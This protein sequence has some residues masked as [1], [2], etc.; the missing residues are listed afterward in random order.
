MTS[1]SGCK[2]MI[3]AINDVYI[4]DNIPKFRTLV[5]LTVAK[6]KP[7]HVFI[8]H[9]GDFLSPS[10]LSNFDKGLNMVQVLNEGGFSHIVLGNHEFDIT[11]IELKSRLNLLKGSILGTNVTFPKNEN[12]EYNVSKYDIT[13]LKP[14]GIKIGW[15]GFL[16][17]ETVT[18][19]KTGGLYPKYEG[20]QVHDPIE[21]A[22]EAILELKTKGVNVIILLTHLD[23]ARDRALAEEAAK[24][25]IKLILGGH[26]HSK[27]VEKKHGVHVV[28][29]G[30]D[31]IE[32]TVA[33]L[34]FRGDGEANE[35][36]S[37]EGLLNIPY[38]VSVDVV[39]VSNVKTDEI[40]Y[41][42]MLE[43]CKEGY[44]KLKSLGS[45]LLIPP[46]PIGIDILSSKNPRNGQCTV[47]R[48]FGDVMKKFFR[49][50]A[51]IINSGKI[52]NKSEYPDGLTLTNIGSE[53]P[54]QDNFTYSV[55]MTPAELEEVLQ[56]SYKNKL[57]A[58]GFLQFDNKTNFDVKTLTLQS[59]NGK[60]VTEKSKSQSIMVAMPI[61]I[62]NGMD[63]II[64]LAKIG[65]RNKTKRVPLDHLM[66]MQDIIIKQCVLDQWDEL[67]LTSLDFKKADRDQDS[68]VE[69]KEFVEYL[70]KSHPEFGKG[71]VDLFWENLDT[72]GNG[73]LTRKEFLRRT[74]LSLDEESMKELVKFR[75]AL[76]EGRLS[77]TSKRSSFLSSATSRQGSSADGGQDTPIKFNVFT[78]R[79]HQSV[80][81][82]EIDE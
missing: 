73:Y 26:D 77:F 62:L 61:S 4:T 67:N 12:K 60:P 41:A 54:F 74:T 65:E 70:Q 38:E 58:A 39:N 75:K 5:D 9:Q 52:R 81:I 1:N 63:G 59:V 3:F 6:E 13:V 30:F 32:A 76:E 68:R 69:N 45:T 2:V 17:P 8:T 25:G 50:D 14:Q 37:G 44:D 20:L 46:S 72:D 47:G 43:I 64:P 21:S 31:A 16:T 10:A 53:L 79:F 36:K 7:D 42:K 29:S 15:L 18:L 71:I 33:T 78:E 80:T 27:F 57:G 66:L 34:T 11:L 55:P 35:K 22:R 24:H 49:A 23:M 56:F 51:A 40:K 28:K 19:L 48:L 82:A